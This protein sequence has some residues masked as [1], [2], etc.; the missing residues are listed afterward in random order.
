MRGSTLSIRAI[1]LPMALVIACVLFFAYLLARYAYDGLYGQDS[2]AYYYQA[3][4]LWNDI[5]GQPQPANWLSTSDGFRWP[6]GYHLHIIAGFLFGGTGP[7]GGRLLT[8]LLAAVTPGLVY[9]IARELWPDMSEGGH[10]GP[11][12]RSAV[13]GLSAGVLLVLNGTYTRFGLSLMSD[14]PALFWSLLALLFFLKAWPVDELRIWKV[15]QVEYDETAKTPSAPRERQEFHWF[16]LR[17]R[18]WAFAAGLAFGVAVLVRYGSLLLLAPV[19]VYL[20]VRRVTQPQR[21]PWKGEVKPFLWAAAGLG[22]ALLPQAAY[23]LTHSAGSGYSD[24]LGDWNIANIFSN[25]VTSTDGTSVYDYPMIAFYLL[26]PLASSSAGFL[27]PFY[28]PALGLGAWTLLR[29]RK[30]AVIALLASW[31][32]IPVLIFSGTAY[33][34]HR[35]VLAYLPALAI[36]CGIG[37]AT[38]LEAIQELQ[39][40]NYKLRIMKQRIVITLVAAGVLL[41]V[42]VGIVQGWRGVDQWVG[43]H[44]AFKEEESKAV[45]MARE[46]AGRTTPRVVSFGT[47]AALFYY[48]RWP[49]LDFY[50]HDEE[51][52]ENFFKEPGERLVVLPEESMSTQWAGTPSGARWEWIRGHYLL[53]LEGKAG[54]YTIYKVQDRP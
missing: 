52:I 29:E 40:T 3:L 38:A 8:L 9:L 12:L 44:I 1:L 15:Y 31:W 10:T 28:L 39:I 49:M 11:P 14:V 25:R 43:T 23:Y 32:L 26:T 21:I 27:S 16:G 45:T 19:V 5:T 51:E 34:S 41:S 2:Y 54:S 33:Q 50:N 6:I 30:W 13:A 4:A 18:H 22:L 42:S 46:A 35:F 24:F 53:Q 37:I 17:K 7:E 47:T 36:V 48:T 20:I